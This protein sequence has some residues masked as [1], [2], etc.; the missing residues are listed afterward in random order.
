M[1][2]VIDNCHTPELEHHLCVQYVD[3]DPGRVLHHHRLLPHHLGQ[4]NLS[5]R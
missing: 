2:I 5:L 3:P 4:M 1:L